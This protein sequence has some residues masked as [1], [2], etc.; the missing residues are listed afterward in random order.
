[1]NG[2]DCV[3]LRGTHSIG[4]WSASGACISISLNKYA[5]TWGLLSLNLHNYLI[6]KNKCSE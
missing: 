2:D 3:L 5:S 6:R 4:R 1:M